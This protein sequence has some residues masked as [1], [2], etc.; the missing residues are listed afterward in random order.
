MSKLLNQLDKK[1]FQAYTIQHGIER[2]RIQ[3]PLEQ[4]KVFED[5]FAVLSSTSASLSTLLELVAACNG[6]TRKVK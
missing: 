1:P 2:V 4:T 5:K 3:I 6:K